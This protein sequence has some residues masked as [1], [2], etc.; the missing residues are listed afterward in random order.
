MAALERTRALMEATAAAIGLPGLPADDTGG[1]HLK[2]G[3]ETDIFIY[4]GDDETI[5]I[6]AP[7]GPLPR[8]TDYALVVYLLQRNRFDADTA[9]FQIAADEVGTLIFWGRLRIADLD[10]ALLAAVLDRVAQRVREIAAE[11]AQAGP[12]P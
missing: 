10:G 8:A 2:I 3:A 6:V 12:P 4:G 5:L 9:P 7:I 1:Y 11:V